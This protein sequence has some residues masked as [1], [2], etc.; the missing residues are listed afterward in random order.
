MGLTL[1]LLSKYLVGLSL[2]HN[3]A[4]PLRIR[5]FRTKKTTKYCL[6]QMSQQQHTD[7]RE[8]LWSHVALLGL[9]LV[10]FKY[11]RIYVETAL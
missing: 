10:N 3:L 4:F 1:V 7:L 6:A 11:F 5:K 2:K 8:T 9:A